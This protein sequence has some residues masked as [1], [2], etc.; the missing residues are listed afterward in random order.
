M[1]QDNSGVKIDFFSF[2]VVKERTAEKYAWEGWQKEA[3]RH[4]DLIEAIY[5]V[6]IGEERV[7]R[8]S[9][10]EKSVYVTSTDGVA[11]YMIGAEDLNTEGWKRKNWCELHTVDFN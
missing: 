9:P 8:V 5:H 6:V 4:L 3:T 2:V 11:T 1:S 7:G 10:W